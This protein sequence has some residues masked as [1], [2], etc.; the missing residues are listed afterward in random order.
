MRATVEARN[1]FG[2]TTRSSEAVTVRVARRAH[3][4]AEVAR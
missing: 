4:Q 3:A 2:N 1:A